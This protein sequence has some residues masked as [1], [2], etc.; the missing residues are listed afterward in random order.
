MQSIVRERFCGSSSNRCGGVTATSNIRRL[1]AR[2]TEWPAFLG[3][4]LFELKLTRANV[5][6]AL[7]LPLYR[8]L[9]V[10]C[11]EI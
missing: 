9:A 3:V 6:K 11:E 2:H 10:K 8:D 1:P 5:S 7:T 4:Y